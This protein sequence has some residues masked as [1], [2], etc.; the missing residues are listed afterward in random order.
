MGGFRMF[1][2]HISPQSLLIIA[3]FILLYPTA[4]TLG[5]LAAVTIHETGHLF[6]ILLGGEK[7]DGIRITPFGLIIQRRDRICSYEKD[8]LILL[9]GPFANLVTGLLLSG[10]PNPVLAALAQASLSFCIVNILP[11]SSLDGGRALEILIR[12]L[13]PKLP[14]G[15]ILRVLSFGTLFCLWIVSVYLMLTGLGGFS[16]FFFCFWLFASL[17]LKKPGISRF[18]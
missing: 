7:V 1:L 3:G 17:F 2:I 12:L 10:H 4:S 15:R 5:I 18:E 9:A 8:L 6:A 11:V 14:A 13:F 16:L